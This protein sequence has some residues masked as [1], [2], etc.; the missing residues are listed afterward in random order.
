MTELIPSFLFSSQKDK[1]YFLF[2]PNVELIRNEY[3]ASI[4]QIK[5]RQ[6]IAGL[7]FSTQ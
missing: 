1:R 5:D 2:H 6:K 7:S 3:P 4:K